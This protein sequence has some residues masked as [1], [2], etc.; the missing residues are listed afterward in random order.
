MT[1]T[2]AF[3]RR[4]VVDPVTV[5]ETTETVYAAVKAQIDTGA[6]V[7]S[8]DATAVTAKRLGRSKGWV[9]KQRSIAR[10]TPDVKTLI[11]SGA[12]SVHAAEG[13]HRVTDPSRQ[14]DEARRRVATGYQPNRPCRCPGHAHTSH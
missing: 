7:G 1:R 10:L 3:D 11:R 13:L 2:Y 4:P 5:A 8:R 6:I 9:S 14:V 12:L